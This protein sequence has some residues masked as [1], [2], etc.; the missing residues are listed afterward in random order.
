MRISVCEYLVSKEEDMSEYCRLSNVS[1][2][3][4]IVIFAYITA[5]LKALRLLEI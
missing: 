5:K 2:I 1:F 3:S 4:L